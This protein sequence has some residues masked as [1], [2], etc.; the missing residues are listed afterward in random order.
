MK[1]C[2][3]PAGPDASGLGSRPGASGPAGPGPDLKK[4][5]PG[6]GAPK[7]KT[8]HETHVYILKIHHALK[9]WKTDMFFDPSQRISP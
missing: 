2:P 9:K 6:P 5:L 3:G 1:S 7:P 8:C 4:A